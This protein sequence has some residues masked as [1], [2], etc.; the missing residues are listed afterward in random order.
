MRTRHNEGLDEATSE[1]RCVVTGE[2][3]PRERLIRLALGP[4]GNVWPDPRGRAP[5]RGGWIGVDRRAL[6][7]AQAKGKLKGG[8]A[9][10][11]KRSDFA[12]PDDIGARIEAALERAA[13]DRLGLEARASMLVT[14]SD[15]IAEEARRGRV[16]LLLHAVDAGEDGSRKLDQAWRV[17][18]ERE[19][20]G[21]GGQTL[22]VGRDKLSVALGRDNV[23]HI[24]V[25]DAGAAR[26]IAEA[27]A[28]WR[29]FIHSHDDGASRPCDSPSQAPTGMPGRQATLQDEGF[30]S[31]HER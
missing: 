10:A 18:R 30:G 5:G 13:L 17:G 24:G 28:R 2:R 12:V 16:Q 25:T 11:F 7:A 19:G 20:S 14:G 31:V 21:E 27:V 6:E 4:D 8:L 9:R 23:V 22:P 1:R 3:Q 26:R 29:F 15:R